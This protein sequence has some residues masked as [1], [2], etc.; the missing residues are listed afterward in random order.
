MS[1]VTPIMIKRAESGKEITVICAKEGCPRTRK[2]DREP[3]DPKTAVA[4]EILC[5]WHEDSEFETPV[6]YDKEGNELSNDPE[7]YK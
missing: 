3:I 1:K 2:V 6:Y 4:I 5:P 7:D